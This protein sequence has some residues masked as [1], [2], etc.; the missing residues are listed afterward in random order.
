MDKVTVCALMYKCHGFKVNVFS[1]L[2]VFTGSSKKLLKAHSLTLM[3]S[4]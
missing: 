4:S 3:L 1:P 2:S